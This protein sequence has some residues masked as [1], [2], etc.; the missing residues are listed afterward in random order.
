M[1]RCDAWEVWGHVS[2]EGGFATKEVSGS[3]FCLRQGFEELQAGFERD[4]REFDKFRKLLLFS[5]KLCGTG[6]GE[7]KVG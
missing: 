4:C 5:R 1:Q 7:H 6:W 2:W 3:F